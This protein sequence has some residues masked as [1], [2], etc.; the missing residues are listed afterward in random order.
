MQSDCSGHA[1]SKSFSIS[2]DG[3][4]SAEA[5]VELIFNH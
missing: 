5:G 1:L 4:I 3:A 2:A